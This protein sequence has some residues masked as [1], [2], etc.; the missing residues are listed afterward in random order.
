MLRIVIIED[1]KLSVDNL[2]ALLKKTALPFTIVA[3]I[4]SVFESVSWL[5]NNFLPDLIFMDIHLSD[6]KSLEIFKEYNITTPVIFTTAYDYYAIQVFKTSGIDYLLK[7]IVYE[8]LKDTLKSFMDKKPIY[9]NNQGIIN[10]SIFN[11][12]K[13]DYKKRFLVKEGK[14]YIPIITDNIAYFHRTGIV[15]V[16]LFDNV[17]Y[18]LNYSLNQLEEIL[19]PNIFIRVNRK[20]IANINSIQQLTKNYNDNYIA[21]LNPSHNEEIQ[22]SQESYTRLREFLS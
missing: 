20:V 22:I 3:E 2:K 12:K 16:K 1:E 9:V 7:P 14:G 4:D 18:S 15:F 13:H 10:D 5:K 11:F 17:S 8:H 6:G 21:K 19:D